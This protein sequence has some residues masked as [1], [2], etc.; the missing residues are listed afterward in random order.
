METNKANK[1]EI[2]QTVT[3]LVRDATGRVVSA[4]FCKIV[5]LFSSVAFVQQDG[6]KFTVMRTN[7]R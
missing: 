7:L 1:M 4:D 5:N 3:L 6:K 2:G